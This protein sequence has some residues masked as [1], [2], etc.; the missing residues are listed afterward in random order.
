MIEFADESVIVGLRQMG[1]L[2]SITLYSPSMH[3]A[4]PCTRT[5]P[6]LLPVVPV[7]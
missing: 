1:V 6:A 4:Y 7:V 5:L 2:L 3:T